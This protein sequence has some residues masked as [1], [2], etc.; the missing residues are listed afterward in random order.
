MEINL[1]NLELSKSPAIAN[2]PA[3][4]KK[5]Q[6]LILTVKEKM[7]LPLTKETNPRIKPT[8]GPLKTKSLTHDLKQTKKV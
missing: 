2:Q 3:H 1:S 7:F 4:L 5:Q 8:P 6:N